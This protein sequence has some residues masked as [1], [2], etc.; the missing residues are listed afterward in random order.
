MKRAVDIVLSAT[1]LVVLA[2]LL[3]I[4][5]L[6]IW[7]D[8]GWPVFFS[9]QRLGRDFRP[10]VLWKFRSMWPA[11]G[12]F[13]TAAGDRRITRVGRFVRR[14]KIDELPQ[15]WNVLLGDMSLVGPRPEVTEF[16]NVYRERYKRILR[17]RPGLTDLASIRYRDE[18]ELLAE[19][20]DPVHRY[21]TF[22]LPDKLD[23]AE[24]YIRDRSFWL[25]VRIIVRTVRI[26]ARV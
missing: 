22:V 13:V 10:F 8:S 14:T 16:V 21:I 24:Q 17:V 25:D 1:A 26:M 3:L 12:S 5:A 11:A 4:V 6:A 20:G 23:L 9:Q 2:P 15:L 19:S 18:E 7:V